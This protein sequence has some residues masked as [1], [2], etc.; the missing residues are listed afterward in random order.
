MKIPLNFEVMRRVH[1][2]DLRRGQFKLT[3]TFCTNCLSS[4]PHFSKVCPVL[5]GNI[6]ILVFKCQSVNINH[7]LT[8]AK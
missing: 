4:C 6:R 5:N 7:K 1:D 2:L 8:V 3:M